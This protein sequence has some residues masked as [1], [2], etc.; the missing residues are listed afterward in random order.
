MMFPFRFDVHCK[1]GVARGDGRVYTRW[2]TRPSAQW[3]SLTGVAAQ[4]AA[5]GGSA[6]IRVELAVS[7]FSRT[8]RRRTVFDGFLNRSAV[9]P[10]RL[11]RLFCPARCGSSWEAW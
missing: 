5:N 10:W 8:H 4:L 1:D 2:Y 11:G 3:A 7:T 9:W 6:P